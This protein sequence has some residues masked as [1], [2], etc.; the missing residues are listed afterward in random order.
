M[1]SGVTARLTVPRTKVIRTWDLGTVSS[2]IGGAVDRIYSPWIGSLVSYPPNCQRSYA[3]G[4]ILWYLPC[5][6]RKT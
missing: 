4:M 3:D 5:Y 6:I 2:A 1:I